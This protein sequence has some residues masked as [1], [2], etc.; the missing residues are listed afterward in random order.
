MKIHKSILLFSLVVAFLMLLNLSC[1]KS[2]TEIDQPPIIITPPSLELSVDGVSC[3]EAWI[4][5][6]KLN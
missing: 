5:V 4:K 1:K 6:K 3:T 2:P